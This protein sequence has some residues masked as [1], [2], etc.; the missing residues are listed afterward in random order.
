[1]LTAIPIAS[2]P[3]VATLAVITYSSNIIIIAISST[4]AYNSS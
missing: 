1:M 2:M 3:M 4:I